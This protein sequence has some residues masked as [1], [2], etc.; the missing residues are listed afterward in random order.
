MI[1]FAKTAHYVCPHLFKLIMWCGE[2][3]PV[4]TGGLR[5]LHQVQAI[6]A[7]RI[8]CID[9]WV[10]PLWTTSL[11]PEIQLNTTSRLRRLSICQRKNLIIARN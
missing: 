4:I 2:N 10:M 11:V 7:A 3:D 9:P 8:I 1:S 6:L 5:K